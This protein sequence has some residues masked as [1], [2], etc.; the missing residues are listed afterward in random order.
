MSGHEYKIIFTGTMGAG[1]TTAIAAL[2]EIPPVSTDVPNS[3]LGAFQK[4]TTTAAFDYG[5]LTLDGGNRLRLYGTPGQER[6]RFMWSILARGALGV[7]VL[8]D[9]SRP[10]PLADLGIYIDN[11]ADVVATGCLTIAVGRLDTHPDPSLDVYY[12][13]LLARDLA[14]PVLA[15]DVRRRDDVL[16]L[17]DTLFSLIEAKVIA[18]EEADAMAPGAAVGD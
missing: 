4:A 3:D 11:F 14:I 8:V 13:W 12:E 5:E 17:V 15:A 1:K 6:F 18:A 7:I 16:V 10:D 9:N 2:S